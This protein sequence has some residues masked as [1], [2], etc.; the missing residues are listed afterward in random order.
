[1]SMQHSQSFSTGEL[2]KT[3]RHGK[4]F[5][6]FLV[7]LGVVCLGTAGF[8]LYLKTI[9]PMQNPP[10]FYGTAGFLLFCSLCAF[11]GAVWQKK[12]RRPSYEVYEKGIAQIIGGQAK[13]TPFSEIEDLYLFSSGQTVMSGLATNLAYRRNAGE[14]FC[15]ISEHLSGFMGFQQLVREL[16][17]RERQPAVL[18]TLASGGA[19]QFNYISTGQVWRKRISG[20]FLN[21]T[22]QPIV[23]T[24]DA[25]EVQGRTVPMSSLRGFDLNAW[26]QKIV[27]KDASGAVV[28]STMSL[29]ILSLDLFLNTLSLVLDESRHAATAA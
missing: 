1:M 27:V 8:V 23:V 24:R 25:L 22:T 6:Y 4:V 7:I 26:T 15:W 11:A 20:K 17:L 2:I 10:L 19:V 18:E 16:Y 28:L 9:A 3:F 29:G 14:P 5:V 12:L 21:V 13:Y